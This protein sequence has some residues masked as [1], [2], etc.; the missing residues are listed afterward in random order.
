MMDPTI[1]AAAAGVG[2]GIIGAIIGGVFALKAT[3]RQ[4]EVMLRQSRGDVNERLYRQSLVIVKFFAE[5]PELRPYFYDNKDLT[6]VNN[7]LEK[8]KVLSAA[9]MVSGFMELVALQIGEQ[10]ADIQPRWKSYIVDSYNSSAVVREHIASC[11]AW[12]ANDLLCLLPT[13][14]LPSANRASD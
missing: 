11:S 1:L 9:E 5:N 2:G 3:K 10:P 7:D 14:S 4:V 8:L 13:D 12:Y 6:R